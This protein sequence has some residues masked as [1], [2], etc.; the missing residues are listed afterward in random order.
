LLSELLI[1]DFALV[2]RIRLHLDGGLVVLTGETGA[3]KSILL[4][5]LG[6]ALGA[7]A[8]GG[9][10]RPGAERTVISAIFEL[11]DAPLARSWL[12][13][14][15][16]EASEGLAIL[17]RQ[18]SADGRSRCQVNGQAVT[19]AQMRE[20]AECLVDI[21]GQNAHQSLVRPEEQRRLLDAWAGHAGLLEVM[22][23]AWSEHEAARA[24]ATALGATLDPALRER[25]LALLTHEIEA[26]QALDCTS[27]ALALLEHAHS[28]SAHAESLRDGVAESL[29]WLDEAE[30][31]AHALIGRA[32]RRL[33]DLSRYDA[34]LGVT[35][36]QLQDAAVLVTDAIAELRD[37]AES[38]EHDPAE[39]ARLESRLAA[40]HAAARRHRCEAADLPGV[41]ARLAA[42]RERLAT[43]EASARALAERVEITGRAV[44]E[45][46]VALSVARQGAAPRFAALVT[47]HMQGLAMA[48]GLLRVAVEAQAGR[49]AR[50]GNDRVE[51]LVSTNRGMEPRPLGKV[52]S[53]GEIARIALAI[54]V[55]LAGDAGVPTLIFDEVDAGIGGRT[56]DVIGRELRRLAGH[57]QV[58]CV[59]HLAQVAAQAGQHFAVSKRT[60]TGQTL[61]EV[62]AL[63]AE[64]R[65]TEIARMLGGVELTPEGLRH[66]GA[67][68][69]LAGH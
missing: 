23:A 63:T 34:R 11:L 47:E 7:R 60:E 26:L 46:A 52:A 49:A 6:L 19:L 10:V 21:H 31:S 28:R 68:L 56:A 42:E 64:A 9:V 57:R 15:G 58:L 22:A 20:L 62:E 17:R 48:G 27:E 1:E 66:A 24:E 43:V 59:T 38:V 14:Q 53:G 54:Q 25:E 37:Q 51:F 65:V 67:L 33:R 30:P 3:G 41:L 16:I 40:V 55:V 32:E 50:H 13:E 5:A 61:T 36:Q 29:A 4:D 69:G 39:L 44:T 12:D 8:D 2:Q 18:L 35:A 45:A